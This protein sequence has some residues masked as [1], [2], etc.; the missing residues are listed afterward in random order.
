LIFGTEHLSDP[1]D[2]AISARLVHG[3]VEA[4]M[5]LYDDIAPQAYALALRLTRSK[6]RAYAAVRCA[7]LRV[8]EQPTMFAD[9]RLSVR[10]RI[11]LEVNHLVLQQ[12][13]T[14]RR[15]TARRG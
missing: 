8:I 6:T 7:F 4:I 13:R 2:C 14:G 11:L 5:E 15:R 1:W 9:R 10:A 3:E 12:R